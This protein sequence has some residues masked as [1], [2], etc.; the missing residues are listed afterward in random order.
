M[1][2]N[3]DPRW[4]ATTNQFLYRLSTK[5]K[6]WSCFG[7][8]DGR[9]DL[10]ISLLLAF[11]T[12]LIISILR[13]LLLVIADCSKPLLPCPVPSPPPKK[14]SQVSVRVTLHKGLM[15]RSTEVGSGENTLVRD[16]GNVS[17]SIGLEKLISCFTVDPVGPVPVL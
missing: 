6:C 14:T 12:L 9:S 3:L 7:V 13:T 16:V 4:S 8:R 10:S 1:T 2:Q 15:F 5:R 17:S 11:S